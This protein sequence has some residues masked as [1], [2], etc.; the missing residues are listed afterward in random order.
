VNVASLLLGGMMLLAG[1]AFALPTQATLPTLHR[2]E[3]TSWSAQVAAL[4]PASFPGLQPIAFHEDR[5]VPELVA[6]VYARLGLPELT[7]AQHELVAVE[8]KALVPS[9]AVALQQ[10][11]GAVDLGVED[12]ATSNTQQAAMRL[13]SAVDAVSPILAEASAHLPPA[14]AKAALFPGPNEGLLFNDPY[15]LILVG[16]P[17][18]SVYK[19]NT[20]SFTLEPEVNLLTI[21]VAGNDIYHDQAGTAV[22]LPNIVCG[23]CHGGVPVSLTLDVVGNDEFRPQRSA[24]AA[25]SLGVGAFG[26]VGIVVDLAGNDAYLDS[27]DPGQGTADVSGIGLLLDANGDDR[28]E[29]EAGSQGFAIDEYSYGALVDM[30][31]SDTYRASLWS[32]GYAENKGSAVFFDACGADTYLSFPG[33]N[34]A[35]WQQTPMGYGFDQAIP[36]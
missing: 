8:V 21:D 27:D 5:S 16:G 29:G 26:G 15:N 2:D 34:G 3:T 35:M 12:W 9:V 6:S 31:G 14:S 4:A 22:P 25:S 20:Y 30:G 24:S 36:C 28:Y 33:A 1:V 7:P 17:G 23:P 11:L 10:L 18:V 32:R 13:L 19:G